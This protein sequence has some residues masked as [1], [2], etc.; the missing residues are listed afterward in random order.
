MLNDVEISNF[1]ENF[2]SSC[3]KV[4]KHS[5]SKGSLITTYIEKRNQMCILLSGSANL[6]RYDFNGNK[7]IIGDLN[8]NDIFGEVLYPTNTNNELFVEAKEDC[9]VLSFIYDN[10]VNCRDIP[11]CKFHREFEE[12]F[13]ILMMN[14]TI[15]LNTRI[16]LLTKK[17]IRDKL[18]GYFNILST[19]K[20]SKT[21]MLPFTL[22]DL[23]YY[24][25]VDR[26]AMMRE[27]S[28]LKEE[29]FIQKKRKKNN[30]TCCLICRVIFN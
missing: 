22:T 7:T 12:K 9:E 1:F 14:N 29:G 27:L 17:N 30:P 15:N 25:N 3:S 23:A 5:F 11:K 4:S 19:R 24:L 10:L 21:F 28:H 18:L 16:E 2:N 6:I 8:K 13:P 20:L 26:S